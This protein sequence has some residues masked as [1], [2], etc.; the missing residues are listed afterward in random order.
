LAPGGVARK[1]QQRSGVRADDVQGGQDLMNLRAER[2]RD[3]MNGDDEATVRP[4]VR[5]R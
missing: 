3:V 1:D 2:L 4:E 5:D